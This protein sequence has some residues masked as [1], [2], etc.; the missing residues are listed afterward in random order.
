[1]RSSE[2]PLSTFNYERDP[3]IKLILH[4]LDID[5]KIQ[6]TFAFNSSLMI[7]D[8]GMPLEL[9]EINFQ[10]FITYFAI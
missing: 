4:M 1:M 9:G 5:K 8:R 3:Y 7:F 6:I 2:F 10:G